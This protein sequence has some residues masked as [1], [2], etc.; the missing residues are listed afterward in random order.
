MYVRTNAKKKKKQYVTSIMSSQKKKKE[1][2]ESDLNPQPLAC[3]SLHYTTE[4]Q[5]HLVIKEVKFY[6][7]YVD[8]W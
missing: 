3:Y 8:M 2:V 6:Y 5:K 7:F 4:P 1:G